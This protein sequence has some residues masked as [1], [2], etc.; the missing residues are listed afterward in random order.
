MGLIHD[1]IEGHFFTH[2]TR[3][4]D[5]RQLLPHPKGITQ[6]S[7][8]VFERLFGLNGSKSDNLCDAVFTVLF[9]DIAND[10][11]A[12]TLVEVHIE[13]RH[14][15]AVGVEEPLKEQSVFQRI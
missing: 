3:G 10:L 5:L 4:H 11:T 9:G 13:V 12:A 2:H 7:R 1:S 14:R 15:D 8:G 6:H